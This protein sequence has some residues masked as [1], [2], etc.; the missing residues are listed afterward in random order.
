MIAAARSELSAQSSVR[1]RWEQICTASDGH[2]LTVT[3]SDGNS[4]QG[5]CFGVDVDGIRVNSPTQGVVKIARKTLS[6]I[7][8][9]SK[10]GNSSLL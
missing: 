3:T 2:E 5:Y 9:E 1:V 8:L 10:K 7:E 4:A 6:R